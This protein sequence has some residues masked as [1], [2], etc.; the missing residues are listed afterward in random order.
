[1]G[2]VDGAW[3]KYE[4]VSRGPKTEVSAAKLNSTQIKVPALHLD[5]TESG[6][7]DALRADGLSCTADNET[8]Q[9]KPGLA[10]KFSAPEAGITYLVATAAT[11]ADFQQVLRHLSGHAVQPLRDWVNQHLDGRSHIAYVAGWRVDLQVVGQ[12]LRLTLF[13]E[14]VWLVMS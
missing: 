4:I 11:S 1:M 5:T 8:C 14:E 10:V 7:A 6:L 12:Q 9:R 2:R 3:G 13:N